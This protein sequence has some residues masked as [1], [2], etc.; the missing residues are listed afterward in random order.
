MHDLISGLFARK[1]NLLP[2]TKEKNFDLSK[3]LSLYGS[4]SKFEFLTNLAIAARKN[5]MSVIWI[6]PFRSSADFEQFN[7]CASSDFDFSP[8][9]VNTGTMPYAHEFQH[10][11][12]F[13]N[14]FK[15]SIWTHAF[16]VYSSSV[17]NCLL[18]S[19]FYFDL[20]LGR[21]EADMK[22]PSSE[23][24]MQEIFSKFLFIFDLEDSLESS[25]DTLN[26]QNLLP[27]TFTRRLAKLG[28]SWVVCSKTQVLGDA[29]LKLNA[30]SS[31]SWHLAQ[32]TSSCPVAPAK[33]CF[34]LRE[35]PQKSNNPLALSSALKS[36]CSTH[37]PVWVSDC[38]EHQSELV[39]A[40]ENKSTVVK[41]VLNFPLSVSPE[42][43]VKPSSSNW[44][45]NSHGF[46]VCLPK[47]LALQLPAHKKESSESSLDF[48][49]NVLIALH[50][51]ELLNC[52]LGLYYLKSAVSVFKNS[53]SRFLYFLSTSEQQGAA[54][55]PSVSFAD[56]CSVF[57]THLNDSLRQ[58][59]A[60]TETKC[61][62]SDFKEILPI[63]YSLLSSNARTF[64]WLC[65]HEMSNTTHGT[66]S[67]KAVP[68][69]DPIDFFNPL[70]GQEQEF[71]SLSFVWSILLRRARKQTYT[72]L[73]IKKSSSPDTEQYPCIYSH[74]KTKGA[75]LLD[76]QNLQL[77]K[78]FFNV[79]CIH[80]ETLV[81]GS[82][83]IKY[84][85]RFS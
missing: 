59:V 70:F 23:K 64:L 38:T 45:Y 13:N 65:A 25:K 7:H 77:E 55:S 37:P 42:F 68:F 21:L 40:L 16:A 61:L 62:E 33:S 29:G 22:S 54:L 63:E 79:L 47:E 57:C 43:V 27:C 3:G 28:S 11:G 44:F 67:V 6:A 85:A 74:F 10:C 75:F 31:A 51:K 30:N 35:F 80:T 36:V 46:K 4:C 48:L 8:F 66:W 32:N 71:F 60:Q 84:F 12:Q 1:R 24:A 83:A 15:N 73:I 26:L 50:S 2:L 81:R 5:S 39:Q 56:L 76:E 17:H 58:F 52:G 78:T 49:T 41:E 20:A 14:A 34:K 72:L 18:N 19:A 53:F 9:S 69:W 82:E